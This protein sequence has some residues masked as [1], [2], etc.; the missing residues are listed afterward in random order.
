MGPEIARPD[1]PTNGRLQIL[2]NVAG[3]F[4]TADYAPQDEDWRLFCLPL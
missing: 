3:Q 1:Q 2:G 4:V